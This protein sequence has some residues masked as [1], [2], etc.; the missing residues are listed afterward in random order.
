[1]T[2]QHTLSD[3]L[4]TFQN[5]HT[6]KTKL[7]TDVAARLSKIVDK[8]PPWKP[9]YIQAVAAGTLNASRILTRAVDA[10]AAEMDGTP[11]VVVD[12]E[13][14]VIYARPG[15]VHPGALLDSKSLPCAWKTCAA[16]FVKTH[17]RQ[18]YC[19]IHKDPR[20]RR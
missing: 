13:P 15:T 7:Y 16:H 19:P 6:T 1:M 18:K 14:V 9:D 4:E 12:T 17:P 3:L 8:S 20:N 2:T 11:A 5:G 10:L